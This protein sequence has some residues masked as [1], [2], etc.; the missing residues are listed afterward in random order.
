MTCPWLPVHTDVLPLPLKTE[1]TLGYC[2]P[3][4]T[5]AVVADNA[6]GMS[7]SAHTN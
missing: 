3:F 4:Q 7:Y 1:V 2:L 6:A 5:V